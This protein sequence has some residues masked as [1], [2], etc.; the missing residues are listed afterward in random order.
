MK[1]YYIPVAVADIEPVD[2]HSFVVEPKLCSY[3]AHQKSSHN[4]SKI[5]VNLAFLLFEWF[6]I[7][8]LFTQ[9]S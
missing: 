5:F 7:N 9:T 4:V 2:E 1:N 8:S 3:K 6:F